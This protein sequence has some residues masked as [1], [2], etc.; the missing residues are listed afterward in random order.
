MDGKDLAR[1]ERY[2]HAEPNTGCW[3]WT[4]FLNDGGYGHASVNRRKTKAHRA[5]YEHYKG[6]IPT[7]LHIDH[8][9]RQRCCVNPDHLEA[10]TQQENIRRGEAGK[11]QTIRTSCPRG[12][13]YSAA[14]ASSTRLRGQKR[15]C[16]TCARV[17]NKA[18]E[19][20]R[21]AERRSRGLTA[22]G[23]T[24]KEPRRP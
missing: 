22:R 12:H 1:F 18:S 13:S 4:G 19:A 6:P 5:S 7:G 17:A 21:R 23:T 11:Y 8:L 10:V 16:R 3:L 14:P 24:P 20:R 15:W 9:C 2:V